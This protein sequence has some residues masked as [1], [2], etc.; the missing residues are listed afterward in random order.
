MLLVFGDY[1]IE[2]RDWWKKWREFEN[3]AVCGDWRSRS[4]W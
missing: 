3:T 1:T 4:Q 2:H